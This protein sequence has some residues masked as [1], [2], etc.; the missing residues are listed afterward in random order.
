MEYKNL[1][2]R[3]TEAEHRALKTKAAQ[4]GKSIKE[5]LLGALREKY[6]DWQG[7]N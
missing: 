4:E 3:L 5:L 6:P 1:T 7:K 2:L